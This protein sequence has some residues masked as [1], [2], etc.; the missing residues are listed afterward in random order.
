M[1]IPALDLTLMLKAG[2]FSTDPEPH[3]FFVGP[4]ADVPQTTGRNRNVPKKAFFIDSGTAFSPTRFMSQRSEIRYA[5][6]LLHFRSFEYRDGR[7]TIMEA[8]DFLLGKKFYVYPGTQKKF[9]DR[10]V[11][12]SLD[13][14][15]KNSDVLNPNNTIKYKR[16]I[17]G[18]DPTKLEY[19][20][21]YTTTSD[22]I[23]SGPDINK[24]HTYTVT[25]NM[26]Y[27]QAAM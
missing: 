27:N 17:D 15:G 1:L 10:V 7:V 9:S 22:P 20:D 25:Y 18:N 13:G 11:W 21:V 3:D 14:S 4:T 6:V 8:V 19:L 23:H 12:H 16:H 2:G 5:R 24:L 26:V